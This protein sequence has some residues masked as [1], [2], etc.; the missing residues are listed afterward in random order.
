MLVERMSEASVANQAESL[1]DSQSAL[2]EFSDATQYSVSGS[3]GSG[4]RGR[5]AGGGMGNA[6][7]FSTP[8]MLAA[9]PASL[10]L[11]TQDSAQITANQHVSLVSGKS[12]HFT[13][14]KSL[15][16][17]VTEKIS[18]FVQ[19]AG[20]KLFAAK[21]AVEIQAQSDEMKLT[22]LKDLTISSSSGKLVL[23]AEKE[24]WIGAGG[25]YIKI[26]PGLIENGTDGQILEKCAS[27]DKTGASSM[28]VPT[29]LTSVDKGCAWRN[30]TASADSAS[31]VVLD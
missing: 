28:R 31:S 2:K 1:E 14:G 23:T 6:N 9:S 8:I 17:S 24:V 7:G 11:S 12:T 13:A 29:Q 5:T 16:A 22:A 19:N 10:G 15:I 21:G 4:S 20:M 27:W 30:K 25:S 18:L 26:G 3:G